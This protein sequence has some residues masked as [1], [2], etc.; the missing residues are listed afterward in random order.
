MTRL[1]DSYRRRMRNG[2][3]VSCI[4]LALYGVLAL[5]LDPIDT[6]LKQ[7]GLGCAAVV[8]GVIGLVTIR[9]LQILP[10]PHCGVELFVELRRSLR[11]RKPEICCP[12][13]KSVL[14]V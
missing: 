5:V 3:L 9:R 14:Q 6:A 4:V 11:N 1:F 10:C 2:V 12:G 8:I 7:I 13:C